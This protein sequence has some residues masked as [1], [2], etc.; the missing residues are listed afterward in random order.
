[1]L[2]HDEA[3]RLHAVVTERKRANRLGTNGSAPPLLKKKKKVKILKEESHNDP[4]VVVSFR[5][6][7]IGHATL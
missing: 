4:D 2:P 1:V 7:G 5:G 3:E 6:D